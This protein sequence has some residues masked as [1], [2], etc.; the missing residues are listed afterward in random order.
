MSTE[1]STELTSD[2][3]FVLLQRQCKAAVYSGFLPDHITHEFK[4][5]CSPEKAVAKAVTI[6]IKGKELGIP[7]MQAFSSITV[8]K[9]KPCL[10]AEL[11][12]ALIYQRVPKV[13]IDFVTPPEKAHIEC[14]V[15]VVRPPSKKPN[16]FKFSLDDAKKAGLLKNDVWVKYPA[17]MLRARVISAFGRA[18]FPDALMGCYTPEEMG[19]VVA[20]EV[21]A[22]PPKKIEVKDATPSDNAPEREESKETEASQ[23]DDGKVNQQDYDDFMEAARSIG[24]TPADITASMKSLFNKSRYNELTS[25]ES[26]DLFKELETVFNNRLEEKQ[27]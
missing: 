7:L 10:S 3:Q 17:A 6:A 11:M 4:K 27:K 23:P 15:H 13:Q 18:K 24:A 2:D 12:M 16:I 5:P 26:G 1:L 25:E 8:I 14:E 22:E 21:P 9:G 19:S 20:P